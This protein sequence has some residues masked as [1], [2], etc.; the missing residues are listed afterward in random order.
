[1]ATGLPPAAVAAA[2][3]LT[4]FVFEHAAIRG[5]V[6]RLA[7]VTRSILACHPYPAPVARALCELLAATAL[8]ASTLKLDGSLIAQLS[9]HGPLRLLVV[10]CDGTLALRAT[11]Q[12]SEAQ[13]AAL[14]ADASL[15]ALAGS[16][17]AR[18]AI[19]LDPRTGGNLYQGIVALDGASIARSIEHYLAT[20]EQLQSRLRLDVRDGEAAG[21]LLQR[22]PAS[23]ADDEAVWRRATTRLSDAAVDVLPPAAPLTLLH[24]LFPRDDLRVFAPRAAR[25]ACK[26]SQERAENALRIAGRDEVEA[27]LAEEGAVEVTCEYCGRVYRFAPTTARALFTAPDR[28]DHTP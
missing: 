27:A 18:L 28:S 25:F 17:A 13:V 12:W 22:L 1:V 20:S 10:E 11:A 2:D 8:L 21:V 9:G 14:G 7:D 24:A 19:T 5:A 26:C 3:T 16:A 15:A 23:T 4:P 6:V